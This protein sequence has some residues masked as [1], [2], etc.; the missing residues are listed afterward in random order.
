MPAVKKPGKPRKRKN[1][2]S[3]KLHLILICL[4]FL[5]LGF[6]QYLIF[7]FSGTSI[8][9]VLRRSGGRVQLGAGATI[10]EIAAVILPTEEDTV[11]PFSVNGVP[12]ELT[13]DKRNILMK[14]DPFPPNG[15]RGREVPKDLTSEQQTIFA[16]MM[17]G[18]EE[19]NYQ[20]AVGGCLFCNAPGGSGGCFKKGT[21][22]GLTYLLL[23]Q[24]YTQP[25]IED[26]L[27][28]WMS[29]FFPGLAV[30]WAKYYVDQGLD[31]TEIP[32]DVLTFS[33]NG[34]LRV[35]AALEGQDLLSSVP[36]QVGGCF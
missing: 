3:Y 13:L 19:E 1:K 9:S 5:V 6:N 29:Y 4:V 27:R 34:K 28:V 31:P 32:I 33:R 2:V 36:D 8:G 23:K 20:D 12:V 15:G 35:E 17:Y 7:S 26:E 30:K 14:F 21:I 24:G 16:D 22:R 10:Q 18:T 25:E 11:R